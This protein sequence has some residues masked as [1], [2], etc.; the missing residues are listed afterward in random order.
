MIYPP[1]GIGKNEQVL[2]MQSFFIFI[3]LMLS[4][5]VSPALRTLIPTALDVAAG[6]RGTIAIFNQ[7]AD[8]NNNSSTDITFILL[9]YY[10]L[11]IIFYSVAPNYRGGF[12][13]AD[14]ILPLPFDVMSM[15]LPLKFP[16]P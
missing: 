2:G 11:L 14:D 15:F 3:V 1:Y 4:G 10:L 8:K 5:T 6:I 16:E 9:L 13:V 12:D 7:Y